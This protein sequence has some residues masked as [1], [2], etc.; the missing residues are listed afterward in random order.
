M[1]GTAKESILWYS[2]QMNPIFYSSESFY[3]VKRII[4]AINCLSSPVSA[5]GNGLVLMAIITT[6]CLHT[7][8]NILIGSLALADFLIGAVVQPMSV[9]FV[10]NKS[11]F[12]NYSY[13]DSVA[14]LGIVCTSI[15]VTLMGAV[16]CERYM[17]LFLHLRYNTLV[18]NTRASIVAL[19]IWLFWLT[20]A[21]SYVL[22]ARDQYLVIADQIA[23][24]L[25][26]IVSSVAIGTSYIKIFFLV[27]HHRRQILSQQAAVFAVSPN[28]LSQT[29]LAITMGYVIGLSTLCYVPTTIVFQVFV[30][31]RKPSSLLFNVFF[32][33]MAIQLTSSSFN[34]VIYCWRRQDIRRATI[35]MIRKLRCRC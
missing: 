34:P 2:E 22:G 23:F 28:T 7:P 10:M 31:Y 6:P 17:A 14:F 11:L 19:V 35:A 12:L 25:G 33:M 9:A 20:I 21:F 16:S 1:N 15:S 26:W 13:Q 24:V 30:A 8:A 4:V 32:L 3:Y 27:R 5:I 29:K 18:T